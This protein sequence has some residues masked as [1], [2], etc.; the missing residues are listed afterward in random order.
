MLKESGGEMSR[1]RW[2]G[3]LYPTV[4]ALVLG[5]TFLFPPESTAIPAFSKIYELKCAACHSA[6]P[7]L[8]D[9]GEDF[10]LSGYRRQGGWELIP[11]VKFLKLGE[12]LTLPGIVALS[13]SATAGY[14]HTLLISTLGD[15]SNPSVKQRETSFNLNEFKLLGG[16]PIGKQI[17]FFLDA[18]LAHTRIRQFYDSTVKVTGAD[19]TMQGPDFPRMAFMSFHDILLP[20]LLNFKGGVFELPTAFSPTI[21]RLSFFPFLVYEMT[22]LDVIADKSIFEL[23]AVDNVDLESEQFRPSKSQV[24]V[25]LF[26][27]LSPALHGIPWL[28]VDYFVGGVNGN[29]TNIDNNNTKDFFARLGVTCR[30]RS[31]TLALGGFG[32]LSGNSLHRAAINPRTDAVYKDRLVRYGP[33][34]RFT[35]NSPIYVNLFSQILIG[36]DDNATGFG[37]EAKWWGGFVQGE[38][39]PLDYLILFGRYDW[40]KGDRFDDTGESVNEEN[41]NIGPVDPRL[42]D[43]VAGIQYYLHENFKLIAEYRHGE[44][45]L[46]AVPADPQQLRKTEEDSGFIGFRVDF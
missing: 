21:R 33:D 36:K 24:G 13:F 8:N 16:S 37:K 12:R 40:I 22:A 25:Q 14:N 27:R 39:K 30:M 42:V 4:I 15:G 2:S 28:Y 20:D 41:G 31:S 45:D 38:V 19:F 7:D 32:Y 34:F 29:N 9:Y 23:V 44:K 5:L 6:S 26:G 11:K 35:L 18:P 46:G 3:V 17:S 10:R 1:G 43:V